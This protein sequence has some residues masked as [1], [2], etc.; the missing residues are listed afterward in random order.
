MNNH[1]L[2]RFIIKAVG[3]ESNVQSLV[4]CA[5]RLRFRLKDST[6]AQTKLLRDNSNVIQV[7]ESGGQY[8]VVIGSN[9]GSIYNAI[10][11]DSNL[12]GEMSNI[13]KKKEN[14]GNIFNQ[15]ID[16][17]SSIFT[18]FLGALAAAGVLKGFL[19]LF[20][21]LGWM[22]TNE[23]AYQILY[24]TADGVFIFLPVLLAFTAAQ[25]F[26]ANQFVAV[27]IAFSLVYPE[28][29]S[30]ASAGKSINFFGIPIILSNGGYT[31][32]VIP[33]ILAV[34]ILSKL[35]YVTKKIVPSFLEMILVPL[36]ELIVM[37]PL[38]F[39][40]IG[41]IGTIIG[42]F[43]GD[44]FNMIYGFSPILA[45]LIMGGFYQV[46]VMFGMHWGLFPLLF[47]G[48]EKQGFT[49]LPPMLLPAVLAQ[50]GASLA[51]ALLTK[52]SKT[53][54]L[55]F[56]GAIT[57]MFGITEPTVYGVT[58]PLKKPFIA[59]CISGGIGGAIMGAFGVKA[60]SA[61][62]L[63]ILTIP[64]FISNIKGVESNIG[65]AIVSAVI[66]FIGGFVL[67]LV[68]RFK[69][70]DEGKNDTPKDNRLKKNAMEKSR[71]IIKS[72]LEGKVLN[73]NQVEDEVFKSGSMGNGLAIEPTTGTV[74]APEDAEVAM[75]FPTGHAIGLKTTD[76]V[77]VLIH[78]GMDTVNL[79][80]RGFEP[81]VKEGEFVKAG[82][83][84]IRFDL[85]LIKKEGYSIVT[86]VVITNTRQ[87]ADV[88]DFE[89][90]DTMVN[91]DLLLVIK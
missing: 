9:V 47:L 54:T 7:V 15:L 1:E 57:S 19:S 77:E 11:E 23:G 34:W 32:S 87:Y 78:I 50:G 24:A 55:A 76:G 10:M 6:V 68:L 41:P 90:K 44:S 38:T 60:F 22:S 70:N 81:L 16:I 21:V 27:A 72:P 52:N 46:F 3:G 65:M 83:E 82:Q 56:S 61:G 69:E 8:Q 86:P 84:L 5:T 26:K 80:G 29:S 28:I 64:T 79:N 85:D 2:G 36:I 53:R 75:I 45:G 25:R 37:V 35:D 59:A 51:V 91:E 39:L 88:L 30:I 73:L 62:L 40:V 63:S 20:I 42:N 43:I 49:I 13:D 71:H 31:S 89:Q 66:S 33:I 74:V 58:L 14:S 18:P 12:G 4:H 48:I 67:T 17:I